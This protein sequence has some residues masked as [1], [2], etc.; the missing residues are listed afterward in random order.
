MSFVACRLS[1]TT[2]P[3]VGSEPY[4]VAVETYRA[5][6]VCSCNVLSDQDVRSAVKAERTCSIRQVYGFLGC[7]A[8]CGRCARIIRCIM[9]EA[10][11]SAR[12]ASSNSDSSAASLQEY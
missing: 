5:M 1:G 6:I 9:D 8:Q 7:R 10:L 11:G 4:Q 12:P 2:D 3:L